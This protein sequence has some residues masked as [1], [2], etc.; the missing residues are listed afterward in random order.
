MNNPITQAIEALEDITAGWKYIR[1]MH[2]DLY[3]VGWDRAQGKAEAALASLRAAQEGDLPPLPEPAC[4]AYEGVCCGNYVTGA[5]YMGERETLC[6]GCPDGAYPDG[7]TADQ[8]RE[9]ARTAIA[10]AGGGVPQGWKLVPVEPTR[11]MRAAFD[12]ADA[13]AREGTPLGD[14]LI[15]YSPD[16]QWAAMLAS[17]PQPEAAPAVAQAD[18]FTQADLNA[19]YAR[20]RADG[21]EACVN[22]MLAAAPEAPA[23]AAP[24]AGE[25]ERALAYLDDLKDDAAVHIWPDDL[26]KCQTSECVVE[27]YSV[28]MGSPDGKTVPLFSRD[29]VAEAVRAALSHKEQP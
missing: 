25:V 7:F 18:K 24:S 17:S 2:G 5:E 27:V 14:P 4:P 11:E 12:K 8:M 26:G 21:W 15:L 28:R 23:Q 29:Q 3:G 20:G 1:S 16:H 9:Y 6:C 19:E 10:A 22:V 13:E